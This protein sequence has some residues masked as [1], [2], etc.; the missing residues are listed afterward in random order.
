MPIQI[1]RKILWHFPGC[2]QCFL[3][4][5]E[6]LNFRKNHNVSIM[7]VYLVVVP[8]LVVRH[9]Y[10]PRLHTVNHSLGHPTTNCCKYIMPLLSSHT[11]CVIMHEWMNEWMDG[12]MGGWVAVWRSCSDVGQI[13]EVTL[14]HARLVL[15]WVTVSGFT[16]WCGKFISCSLIN[17]HGQLSHSSS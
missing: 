12:W 10:F 6:L 13:N 5:P 1:K 8:G 15:G 17:H 7:Y 9:V 3:V 4:F 16:S 2:N 14:R 11:V